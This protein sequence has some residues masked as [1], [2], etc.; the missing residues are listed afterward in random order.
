MVV[1]GLADHLAAMRDCLHVVLVLVAGLI[2]GILGG[3]GG[4]VGGSGMVGV[5]K[6]RI[7]KPLAA[8]RAAFPKKG[9]KAVAALAILKFPCMSWLRVVTVGNK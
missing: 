7:I 1:L 4:G 3:G 9:C 2:Q 6:S 8:L 5:D